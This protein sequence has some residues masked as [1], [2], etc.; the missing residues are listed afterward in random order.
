[1]EWSDPGSF[2][3]SDRLEKL[4]SPGPTVKYD[5]ARL[6]PGCRRPGLVPTEVS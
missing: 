4:D 2:Q 6:R 1:M 3:G 5:S